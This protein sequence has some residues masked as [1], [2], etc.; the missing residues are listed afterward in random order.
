[1]SSSTGKNDRRSPE[2]EKFISYEGKAVSI[3]K[4]A[5]DRPK[6]HKIQ[7]AKVEV[8]GANRERSARN[9]ENSCTVGV[10][11]QFLDFG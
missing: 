11:F 4:R 2:D 9:S 3:A 8:M 5:T 7:E 1:M 10:N 6:V